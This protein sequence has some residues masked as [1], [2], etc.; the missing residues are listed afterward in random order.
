MGLLYNGT[1]LLWHGY[2]IY[3]ASSG[4]PGHQTPAD[5]CLKDLGP[6]P[7][8]EYNVP[9]RLGGFAYAT[10]VTP[11]LKVEYDKEDSIENMPTNIEFGN[12][13]SR[14]PIAHSPD[15]GCHRVRLSKIRLSEPKCE[16][17]DG[18]YIHDSTKG[19]SAGCIETEHR[20]F[21]QLIQ[22]AKS[23]PAKGGTRSL[24]LVVDYSAQTAKGASATT[25]GGTQQRHWAPKHIPGNVDT[26]Y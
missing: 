3:K 16:Q 9:V 24:L 23:Q 18:F 21:E 15:W 25:Y 12:V 7:E 5:Q 20:F 17:R 22:F 2:G 26:N 1:T 19:Y 11:Q 8:G 13:T 14:G 4:T 6:I 10:N